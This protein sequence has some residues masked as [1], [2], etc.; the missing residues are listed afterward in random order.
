MSSLFDCSYLHKHN[1]LF[2]AFF[3]SKYGKL[4]WKWVV[5]GVVIGAALGAVTGWGGTNYLKWIVEGAHG[6]TKGVWEL[7]IDPVKNVIVHFL[8]KT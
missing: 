2:C 1:V 4:D 3:I 8:F 5:G 6:S 7:V